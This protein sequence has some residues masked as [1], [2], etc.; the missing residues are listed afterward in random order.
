MSFSSF[1][2]SVVLGFISFIISSTYEFRVIQPQSQTVN[3]DGWVSISC[4]HT[5]QVTASN[6]R[7]V[8]LKEYR[9]G[10]FS[11]IC[12]RGRQSSCK[13]VLM[14]EKNSS[15]YIFIMFNIGP[16]EMNSTYVCE[17]TVVMDQIDKTKTGTPTT[18][19]QSTKCEKMAVHPCATAA[20]PLPPQSNPL[21]WI[22][23]AGL[24]LMVLYS[25][26]I[27]SFYIRLMNINKENPTSENSTYVEMRKAPPYHQPEP[28][29]SGIRKFG[30]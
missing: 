17:V 11:R 14:Y 27:T 21:Q 30:H 24:A 4:E 19:L 9:D 22:L 13:N 29:Y 2:A 12:Q 15:S 8:Q 16:K 23:V 25:C 10:K 20:P 18:L 5:A 6:V 28:E 3:P 7:D 26:V 1:S